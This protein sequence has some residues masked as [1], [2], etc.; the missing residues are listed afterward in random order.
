[1]TRIEQLTAT[2]SV[3]SDEPSFGDRLRAA[4]EALDDVDPTEE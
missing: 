4:S 2:I 1:M 3:A